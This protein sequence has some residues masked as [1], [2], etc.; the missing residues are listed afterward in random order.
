MTMSD[1]DRMRRA[2]FFDSHDFK[3]FVFPVLAER[4]HEHI[5]RMLDGKEPYRYRVKE[6]RELADLF[7]QIADEARAS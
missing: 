2:E 7:D 4:E 5:E 3:R 1:E 6:L